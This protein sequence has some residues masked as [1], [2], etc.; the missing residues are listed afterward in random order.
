MNMFKLNIDG[1]EI[2]FLNSWRGTGSGFMH[3]TELYHVFHR[4]WRCLKQTEMSHQKNQMLN[5][6]NL[7]STNLQPNFGLSTAL[8][9]N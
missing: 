2:L 7:C 3:E 9:T 4:Y 1:K 5:R 8:S 6:P